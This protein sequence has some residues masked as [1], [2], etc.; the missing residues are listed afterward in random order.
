MDAALYL[1]LGMIDSAMIV[2]LALA[3][4][5]WPYRSYK[6]EIAAVSVL[7]SCL[8]Y[9]VR[10]KMEQP[11][12]FDILM[13]FITYLIFFIFVIKVKPLRATIAAL[14]GYVSFIGV[15]LLILSVLKLLTAVGSGTVTDTV[16]ASVWMF[17]T[18]CQTAC[19]LIIVGMHRY[20]LGST[21]WPAPPHP[22]FIRD[23]ITAL[24]VAIVVFSIAVIY[25]AAFLVFHAESRYFVAIPLVMAALG[26]LYHFSS[27][28]ES[29]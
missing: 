14:S 24:K 22:F 8:S 6:I 16:G 18:I 2:L 1:F 11:F 10:V 28:K 19:L 23:R 13:Q 15:Q 26:W 21:K 20:N 29:V 27:K 25:T 12:I 17:Q 7:G 3:W 5:R 4:Y 9:I